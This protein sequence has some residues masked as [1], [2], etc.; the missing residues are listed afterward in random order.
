M[1][2]YVVLLESDEE[3]LDTS[4]KWLVEVLETIQIIAHSCGVLPTGE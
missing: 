1:L 4:R 2:N 3:I